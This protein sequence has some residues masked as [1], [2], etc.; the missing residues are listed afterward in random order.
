MA[1]AGV[2]LAGFGLGLTGVGVGGV[3]SKQQL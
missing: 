1:G 3:V 2:G